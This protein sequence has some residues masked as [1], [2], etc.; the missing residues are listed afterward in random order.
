MPLISEVFHK[1]I[2]DENHINIETKYIVGNNI[3]TR[4]TNNYHNDDVL[5]GIICEKKYYLNNKL[6]HTEKDFDSR[7]EYTYISQIKEEEEYKCLNCG[8][9]SKIKDFIDGCPYCK[10]NYNIDYEIKDKGSKYTYDLVLK[11]PIYRIITGVVDLIISLILSY[12]F[13]ITTSRTFN[14]YDISKVF[15][16]GFIIALILYYFFY[17]L[18]AYIILNP[19][20]KYK[21]KEN[22]EQMKFWSKT[23]IDKQTF[24]N[25]LHYE[26]DHEYYVNKKIID[27]DILD[28]LEFNDYL[29]DG[30]MYVK[31][32]VN[33]RIITLE[34]NEFKK[35]LKNEVIT[36][37]KNENNLT[38]NNKVNMIRCSN[39]GSSIDA[40]KQKCEYCGSEIK[41]IQEWIMVNN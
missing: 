30:I 13:I 24:F 23:N 1:Q 38:L 14:V 12:I 40:T 26:M 16:Y 7:M 18:D 34:N 19:I 36:L 2:L 9:T 37:K 6:K 25:N 15:I 5:K 8:V 17:T 32:K 10:T 20:R 35:E 33:I 4:N 21:E 22:E 28:Y 27:Y 11:S 39:C 3:L 29:E 41:Y 31:V